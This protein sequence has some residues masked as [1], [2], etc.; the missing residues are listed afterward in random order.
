MPKRAGILTG[1]AFAVSLFSFHGTAAQA[2][3][4]ANPSA[5]SLDN[6]YRNTRLSMETNRQN[7]SNVVIAR[8]AAM[9]AGGAGSLYDE[10]QDA[11]GYQNVI[12]VPLENIGEG[13]VINVNVGDAQQSAADSNVDAGNS[14]AENSTL[15]NTTTGSTAC[16][17]LLNGGSNCSGGSN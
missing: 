14:V 10:Y 1:L 13:A 4:F 15:T 5:A 3:D 11:Q 7:Q 12:W 9:Q 17:S 2:G 6:N 16:G 8:E